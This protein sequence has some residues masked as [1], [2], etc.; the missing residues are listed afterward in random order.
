MLFAAAAACTAPAASAA[1]DSGKAAEAH[2][3]AS[4]GT[5]VMIPE[6]QNELAAEHWRDAS[7]RQI[8]H[9]SLGGSR[10]RVRIS[11]TYGTAPLVL[12]GAAVA[13]AKAPGKAD[14]DGASARP[15][16]FNGRTSVLIPSGGEYYS[17]PVALEHKAGADLAISMYFKGEPARQTGHPGSRTNSFVIKGNRVMDAEWPA[18]AKVER[19]YALADV[20]VQAPRSVGA[21]VAIGDSI[22]DGNG[23][24][25]DGNDRWPDLL[26][27]RFAREGQVM[28][29]VNAGIGGGRLLRDG[30]G[31]NMVSRFD[32]D[33]I[34]RSGV[35]HA[36]VMIGVNDLGGQHRN[37]DNSPEARKK[38]LDDMM[39]AHRQLVERAHAQGIC[40]IGGTVSPYS[41]SDYYRPNADN[42]ADRVALNNWIRTSGV[43]D[44]VADFDAA[45]RDPARPSHLLKERDKGDGLHPSPAG[46]RAMAD[47]VPLDA[48]RQCAVRR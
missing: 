15:L 38:L 34:A 42:E 46:F 4:W 29:V 17:D 44:G 25:T 35:T 12:E 19:W 6:G 41:G 18:A 27:A 9:L 2:W 28:G 13:L 20:E 5:A 43:F 3:V 31:P 7:L 14:V 21:V 24:T 22:T 37:G 10:L 33:V 16:T 26:A 36:I 23:S 48:L 40:V 39:T 30:L 47:A 32:R 45:L 11:N 1:V 8:V